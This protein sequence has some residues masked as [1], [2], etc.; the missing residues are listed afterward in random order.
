ML[1]NMFSKLLGKKLNY[2][3]TFTNYT[4]CFDGWMDLSG[5][6]IY[7]FMVLK[8]ECDDVLDIIDLSGFRHTALE[9]KNQLLS[10]KV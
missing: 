2:L 10:I 5:N 6:S 4:L 1:T 3:P 8:E 7:S 9:L